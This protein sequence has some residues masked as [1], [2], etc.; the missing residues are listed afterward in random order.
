MTITATWRFLE[1]QSARHASGDRTS[2]LPASRRTVGDRA[3]PPLPLKRRTASQ[4]A[5][6]PQIDPPDPTRTAP[7]L[8]ARL[9]QTCA[10]AITVRSTP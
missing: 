7:N 3:R 10:P 9:T 6:D 5:V 8:A 1:R 2:E 4:G